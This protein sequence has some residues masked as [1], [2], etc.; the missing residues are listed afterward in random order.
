MD[1]SQRTAQTRR[2]AL[3]DDR[4]SGRQLNGSLRSGRGSGN[5]YQLKSR[6]IRFRGKGNA[7]MTRFGGLDPRKLIMLALGV[8]LAILLFFLVSSCVRS[9]KAKTPETSAADNRVSAGVSDE[10]V[11]AFTEALDRGEA[12]QWIALHASE[13]PSE[14]LP[15]LALEIPEA[16]P[17]VRAYPESSKNASAFGESVSRGEVPLLYNWDQRWGAVEYDGS[18]LAVTGSGPT[19]FSMIY[20]GL[21]GKADK[22][23][24]DMASLATA[25]GLTGGEAHTTT[26]FFV[27][28]AKELGLSVEELEASSDN[29]SDALDSGTFVLVEVRSETLT[30]QTHWVVVAYENE[31]GSVRVYDPTSPMVSARPWD[32]ATISSASIHMYS[33]TLADAEEE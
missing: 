7:G 24:A 12:L 27:M 14:D 10:L 23:P 17:F 33:V 20:M 1:Y 28:A 13:Y 21:T 8:V 4:R 2:G 11:G 22:T 31:N 25:K 5:R 9:C 16:I 15:R 26:D 29:L 32:P 19:S 18:A 3:T 6:N 30:S